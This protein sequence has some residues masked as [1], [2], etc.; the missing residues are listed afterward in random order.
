MKRFLLGITTFGAAAFL[1]GCPIYSD[2]GNYRVCDSQTCWDCPDTTL[3][4]ACVQWPCNSSDDCGNG[5]LCDYNSRTC[6]SGI[7]STDTSTDTSTSTGT[8]TTA[9]CGADA[10]CPSGEVCGQDL[11]CHLGDCG[12]WGCPASLTCVVVMGSA[13]CLA[14]SQTLGDGA[15]PSTADAGDSSTSAP[16]ANDA[17]LI[18]GPFV[19]GAS[20]AS[21]DSA[22]LADATA[23][24]AP[25][26][27]V[28]CNSD[29]ACGSSGA[30]CVDGICTAQTAL[31]FDSTQC[32]AGDSCVDGLCT[33]Q[34]GPGGVCPT[35]FSC[36]FTSGR[37]VCSYNPSPCSAAAPCQ[38]G[39]ACVE[40]HCALPCP[41]VADAGDAS[42]CPGS[43]IC[44]NGGCIPDQHATL[45]CTNNG[46][47]GSFANACDD[48]AI[49]LH[50]D[51]LTAC[52]LV[53]GADDCAAPNA[54]TTVTSGSNSYRVC[55]NGANL[56]NACDPADP[57]AAPCET[58]LICIDGVCR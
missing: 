34:C 6:T 47:S 32:G 23:E 2:T 33:P 43:E 28:R 10:L 17:A 4:N 30:R 55:G 53:D 14:S 45:W 19:D 3:S 35:G 25:P 11:S 38:N 7:P 44:V 15:A 9:S 46:S 12:T 21:F 42:A 40:G 27:I 31:C 39:G 49:C 18:D 26:P 52:G 48:N 54:C 37:N 50:H 22:P 13:Q 41:F 58:G 8:T 36:D 51:C 16:L 29:T 24:A 5:Y 1:A 20:D 56:T 57:T